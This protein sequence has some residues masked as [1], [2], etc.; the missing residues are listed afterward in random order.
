MALVGTLIAEEVI[1]DVLIPW[2]VSSEVIGIGSSV[3]GSGIA[4][5]EESK[6][7]IQ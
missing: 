7:P 5:V 2:W 1:K 4:A 3:I 6:D